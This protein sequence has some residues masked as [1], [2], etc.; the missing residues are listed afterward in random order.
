MASGAAAAVL[1]PISEDSSIPERDI[2]QWLRGQDG[3]LIKADADVL[4]DGAAAVAFSSGET[5]AMTDTN[6]R[7]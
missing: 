5:V 7:F 6:L 1:A 2:T 3:R 4:G